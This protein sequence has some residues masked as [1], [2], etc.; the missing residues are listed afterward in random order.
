MSRGAA[1]LDAL[2]EC[3]A[4]I[5]CIRQRG[6]L[7][8]FVNALGRAGL[9]GRRRVGDDGCQFQRLAVTEQADFHLVAHAHQADAVAQLAVGFDRLTV[10]GRDDV[11]GVNAGFL[12]R[13]AFD[14]LRY[15][16]AQGVG[17]PQGV[18][19]V[20]CHGVHADAE[21]AAFHGTVLDELVHHAV[22]HVHRNRE[23]DADVAAAAREDGGVDADEL[24]AQIHQG[25]A[26]VAR[27]DGGVGLDE[28]LVAVRIDAGAGQAAD[29]SGC[30]GV[31][32]T[33]RV[34]D[35]QHEIAD[36]D[37]ARITEADLHE[38]AVALHFQ[39]GDI[40]RLVAAD[41][42]RFQVA[43]ILQRDGDLARVLDDVCV[44]DD[45]ALFGVEN[46]T[47]PGALKRSLPRTIFG[48]H[49]EE[50]AEKRIIEQR[51][52]RS[53]VFDRAARGDVHHGGG[54]LLDDR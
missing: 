40:R 16:R 7:E 17:E 48:R 20:R 28:V 22:G 18:R 9:R 44:G 51:I 2:H 43:A 36:L 12:R 4:A 14:D 5:R 3:A 31:L 37:L 53:P 24:T 34:A 25:T 32:Q 50:A 38:C 47:G 39:Y 29:D 52:L 19:D 54:H 15:Q 26:G 46:D 21:L 41:D 1:G 13:R 45:V 27:V 11:T 23:P 10:H 30:N 49:V 35:R 6:A 42:F 8:G 33:E